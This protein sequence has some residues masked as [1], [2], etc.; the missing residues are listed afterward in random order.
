MIWATLLIAMEIGVFYGAVQHFQLFLDNHVSSWLLS[1]LQVD[2]LSS[3]QHSLWPSGTSSM[4]FCE[5]KPF[6]FSKLLN[7]GFIRYSVIYFVCVFL[8]RPSDPWN[9]L[10]FPCI[11]AIPTE[12]IFVGK[13][14][15]NHFPA[16]ASPSPA[17]PFWTLEEH[18][19][20]TAHW[21]V[22]NSHLN[23][24]LEVAKN[25]FRHIIIVN[26]D[27]ARSDVYPFHPHAFIRAQFE[28]NGESSSEPPRMI[29][30]PH[31]STP[32]ISFSSTR[33]TDET[34]GPLEAE[35]LTKNANHDIPVNQHPTPLLPQPHD[36]PVTPFLTQIAKHS[37][38]SLVESPMF[39]IASY[40]TK[41]VVSLLCGVY[42]LDMNYNFEVAFPIPS[43]C[44]PQA[45]H[46]LFPHP[47]SGQD[48]VDLVDRYELD[49]VDVEVLDFMRKERLGVKNDVVEHKIASQLHSSRV[50]ES[51][52]ISAH[53]QSSAFATQDLSRRLLSR[54]GF[55]FL[56]SG[57]DVREAMTTTSP[58][59]RNFLRSSTAPVRDH[60]LLPFIFRLVDMINS[61][62][63]KRMFVHVQMNDILRD[64]RYLE[65]LESGLMPFTQ[66]YFNKH[67]DRL[68]NYLNGARYVD[69]FVEALVNGLKRRRLHLDTLI[70]FTGNH[71]TGMGERGQIGVEENPYDSAFHVPFVL[72]PMEVN[73]PLLINGTWN[74][75]DLAP[76]IL[77]I[78]TGLERQ[79]EVDMVAAMD[80]LSML[81][82]TVKRTVFGLVTPGNAFLIARL[83]RFKVIFDTKEMSASSSELVFN[84]GDGDEQTIPDSEIHG[85]LKHW[86]DSCAT[87]VRRWSSLNRKRY[88]VSPSMY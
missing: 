45:L 13:W 21:H 73:E 32:A 86:R 43:Q 44:L 6:D 84:N 41:S 25:R 56:W 24:H 2:T 30:T 58:R 7:L 39:A 54:M 1:I 69:L 42:P 14:T 51:E 12:M 40:Y 80:G 76:T 16:V 5:E 60:H 20:A 57:E 3:K 36:I 64:S 48:D 50:D 38:V 17:I 72:Y 88:S 63:H 23:R 67:S 28:K 8:F 10:T 27:N 15:S 19:E 53:F 4:A 81:R 46:R 68:N 52:F 61:R 71:G 18:E 66:F 22:S 26:M 70:I 35:T 74:H 29:L 62:M 75:L 49:V 87:M 79:E 34:T 9:R 59:F 47:Q 78:L 31:S 37:M 77:D 82:P 85:A 33:G 11:I 55:D 83:G 65:D